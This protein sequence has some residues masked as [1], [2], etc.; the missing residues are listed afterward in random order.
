MVWKCR[1]GHYNHNTLNACFTCGAP[2]P[3]TLKQGEIEYTLYLD[4]LD[5]G[6]SFSKTVFVK[7]P[8]NICT[9]ADHSRIVVSGTSNGGM[10]TVFA[11]FPWNNSTPHGSP[12]MVYPLAEGG[13]EISCTSSK[14][15][16]DGSDGDT[17]GN[18]KT[19]E[20]GTVVSLSDTMAIKLEDFYGP[21]FTKGGLSPAG[22]KIPNGVPEKIM[23]R[24]PGSEFYYYNGLNA[25]A[26]SM[27]LAM[28]IREH[29]PSANADLRFLNLYTLSKY[30]IRAKQA[31]D[32]LKELGGR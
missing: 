19:V 5:R 20:S 8:V 27:Y 25:F 23:Y 11:S 29:T 13:F 30:D 26:S 2:K 1:C 14:F 3:G 4:F 10:Q 21:S 32:T 31:R 28:G 22:D 9:D 16:I 6:K 15:M 18:K 24:P 7:G 12:L 17:S